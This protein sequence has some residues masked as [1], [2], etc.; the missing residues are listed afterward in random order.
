MPDSVLDDDWE[1]TGRKMSAL[2]LCIPDA[3]PSPLQAS[4]I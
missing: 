4:F 2:S 3:T 1:E